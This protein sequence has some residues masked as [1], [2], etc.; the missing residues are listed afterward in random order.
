MPSKDPE[1]CVHLSI[2]R[3]ANSWYCNDCGAEFV[4]KNPKHRTKWSDAK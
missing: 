3:V 4:P 1:N 2:R